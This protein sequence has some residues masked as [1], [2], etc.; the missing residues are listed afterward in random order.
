MLKKEG[1]AQAKASGGQERR[2]AHKWPGRETVRWV[3]RWG[4]GVALRAEEA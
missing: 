2:M 3:G 1:A 4:W